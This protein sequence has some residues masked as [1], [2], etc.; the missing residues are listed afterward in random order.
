MIRSGMLAPHDRRL[1]LALA[2]AGAS[3]AGYWLP[4]LSIVSATARRTFG[5][6]ATVAEEAD[7]VALTFDDGPHPQ[8]TPAVLE[9][10]A[11]EGIRATFFLV[12]EQVRRR[13]ALAAEIVAAGHAVGV[14]CDRHRNLLRLAPWQVRGDLERAEGAIS[15]A[16]GLRP[17]LYRPPYGIL[18]APA[19]AHARGRAWQTFLWRRDGRDWRAGPEEIVARMLRGV[20]AGDVL[21][22]HDADYYSRP[23]SWRATLEALPAI[24]DGL[25]VRGLEPGAA[26]LAPVPAA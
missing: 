26:L 6:R 19:L 2:C 14:H 25:R 23:Q 9:L 8:G 10:L 15:A 22:A 7:A 20:R 24:I 1:A 5:V 11:R 3:L 17:R 16:T 13:P 12:G 21:L 4:S 18:T